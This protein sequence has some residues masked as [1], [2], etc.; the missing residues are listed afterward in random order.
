MTDPKQAFMALMQQRDASLQNDLAPKPAA[1]DNEINAGF[2][3]NRQQAFQ[4]RMNAYGQKLRN[5]AYA[6]V[7]PTME[8]VSM[9]QIGMGDL[10][11]EH[12]MG[13]KINIPNNTPKQ[14]SK[15]YSRP[16]EY[17]TQG[18]NNARVFEPGRGYLLDDGTYTTSSTLSGAKKSFMERL[19]G[20]PD[21]DA[22]E[23]IKQRQAML[24][25]Q[26][27]KRAQLYGQSDRDDYKLSES[28]ARI[29]EPGR[30]YLM[31]DG[32]YYQKQ[33]GFDKLLNILKQEFFSGTSDNE[34]TEDQSISNQAF[35]QVTPWYMRGL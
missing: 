23:A 18:P 19:F 24:Q 21:L 7:K 13:S 28:G 26:S 14:P 27:T 6:S 8:G 2:L 35:D 3:G 11:Y 5:D 29:F 20:G 4:T 31:Q 17:V 15:K 30:G 1:L 32:S 12:D 16:A 25:K 34:M 9:D 33:S 22:I 10:S